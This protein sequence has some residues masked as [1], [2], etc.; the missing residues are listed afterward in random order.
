MRQFYLERQ[1][2]VSGVSG[3]GRVAEG[4]QFHN[5]WVALTWYGEHLSL[6]W[7]PDM[8][9]VERLHGH[10]GRTLVAWVGEGPDG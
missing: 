2:D 3:L 8:A 9:T 1:E 6:Y 7:Y 5:G 10:Q 4:C